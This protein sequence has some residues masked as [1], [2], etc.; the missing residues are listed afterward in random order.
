MWPGVQVLC[1]SVYVRVSAVQP[2][3]L[4]LERN[5]RSRRLS[6]LSA[7]VTSL[8]QAVLVRPLWLRLLLWLPRKESRVFVRC[9]SIEARED[10]PVFGTARFPL[11]K[12][13]RVTIT[14]PLRLGAERLRRG[15]FEQEIRPI[16]N[17]SLRLVKGFCIRGPTRTIEKR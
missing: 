10:F 4:P 2:E 17:H 15:S 16:G 7:E 12:K 9:R 5:E 13:P 3:R 11:Q 8:L 6:K 1:N 14:E